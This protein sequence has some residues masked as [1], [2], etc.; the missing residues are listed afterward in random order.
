MIKFSEIIK[1][2]MHD[3]M[4]KDKSVICF[5]LGVTDPIGIFGTTSGLE[6]KFGKNRVFDVPTSENALTGI[7]IGASLNGIKPILTHQRAD[8]ILLSMDQLINS[9]SK[10]N[11][12]FGG[13]SNVNITVRC[14]VGKGWGQGPTHSQNLHS[15]FSH[16]PG[17][18]VVC[19]SFASDVYDLFINSVLDPNPVIF[20]EHRWLHNSLGKINIK[21]NKK[22]IL[23][24]KLICKGNK[25][26]IV[27]LSYLSLEAKIVC[28]YLKKNH[29]IDIDLIDLRVT[30]PLDFQEIRKSLKKTGK[31]LLIEPGFTNCSISDTIISKI[32]LEGIKLIKKPIIL[33][34]PNFPEPTSHRLT[35]YYYINRLSIV[36]NIFKLLD[37]KSPKI[38]IQNII[39]H[40]KPGEWFKGPF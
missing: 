23:K 30:N 39:P 21:K 38:Q 28:D 14:I 35:K 5:G 19:P 1:K 34:Q 13:V 8:F 12:M 6:K 11:Y 37:V 10:W 3:L 27:T 7:A 2:A 25:L 15:M 32:S 16:F 26:S 22:N 33:A 24:P 9:A 40:D 31:L 29:S 4:Q 17:I 18:K 36:D 20:L